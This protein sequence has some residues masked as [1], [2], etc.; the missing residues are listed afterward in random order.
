MKSLKA[1]FA[2]LALTSSLVGAGSAMAQSAPLE[3]TPNAADQCAKLESAESRKICLDLG[4]VVN[5]LKSGDTNEV[6][7]LQNNMHTKQIESRKVE[8]TE[9]LNVFRAPSPS[10]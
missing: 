7:R 6:S 8:K 3:G 5:A 4:R 1:S 10:Y 2:V 9:A